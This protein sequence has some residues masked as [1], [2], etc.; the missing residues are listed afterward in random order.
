MAICLLI[1]GFAF[2]IP[3]DGPG[4]NRRVGV[5]AAAIYVYMAFYSPG[6]GVRLHSSVIN[7]P[8]WVPQGADAYL[9][10]SL[11]RSPTVP[12]P[13]PCTFGIS[14]CPMPRPSAGFSSECLS[15]NVSEYN[16]ELTKLATP[17]FV[18]AITFP[19]ML[20]AFK[21]QGAFGWYGKP[22][23]LIRK[24]SLIVLT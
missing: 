16:I 22:H 18:L 14:G 2:Y 17:S 23:H 24:R 9:H 5:V 15:R 6:E 4:D 3:F 13:S 21:P 20:T 11:Y 7:S 19:L 12:R 10:L 8:T 1:T